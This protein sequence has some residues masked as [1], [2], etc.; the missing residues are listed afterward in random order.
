MSDSPDKQS[1]GDVRAGGRFLTLLAAPLNVDALRALEQDSTMSLVELR[2]AAGLPP[3]TTLRGHLREMTEL[4]LL[5]RHPRARATDHAYVELTAVG[6]EFLED[7]DVVASWLARCPAGPVEL[8]TQLAK[9]IL[10]ALVYGWSAMLVHAFA[11]RPYSMTELAGA[12]D[13]NY[14]AIERRMTAMRS[15]GMLAPAPGDGRVRPYEPSEWLRRAVGPL[16]IASRWEQVNSIPV[17]QSFS[18]RDMEAALSLVV[19]LLRLP[20]SASGSCRLEIEAPGKDSSIAGIAFE[21]KRGQLVYSTAQLADEAEASASAPPTE[22]FWAVAE[23][24]P[25]QLSLGGDKSLARAAIAGIHQVL[26]D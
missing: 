11:A 7:A 19:P 9:N 23:N 26:F 3:Q 2:R 14:P 13:L 12:I 22:W 5:E 8:G 20:R 1:D 25:D 17:T 10:K 16:T 24:D 21:A 15:L 18:Q 4:G 6:F